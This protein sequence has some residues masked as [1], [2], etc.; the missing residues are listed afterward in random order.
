MPK[1]RTVIARL[2]APYI[3]TEIKTQLEPYIQD[4]VYDSL[5]ARA[6]VEALAAHVGVDIVIDPETLDTTL[7]KR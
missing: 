4:A 6:Q 3:W 5:N 1:I 7:V 2:L